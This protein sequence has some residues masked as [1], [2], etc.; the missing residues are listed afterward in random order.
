MAH[1]KSDDCREKCVANVIR[2]VTGWGYP[3]DPS[4]LIKNYS[5]KPCPIRSAKY[6]SKIK[7]SEDT[8]F[9]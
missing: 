8:G 2:K 9:L 7:S 1:E 3:V 4:L 5:K 6:K